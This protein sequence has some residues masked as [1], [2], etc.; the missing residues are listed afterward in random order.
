MV[1]YIFTSTET[2]R[3]VRT[4]SPGWPPRLSHSSWTM[5]APSYAVLSIILYL[6]VTRCLHVAHSPPLLYHLPPSP[7]PHRLPPPLTVLLGRVLYIIIVI[8]T[9][10]ILSYLSTNQ[11]TGLILSYLSTNQ[12]T[13]LYLLREGTGNGLFVILTE[14]V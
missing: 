2:R 3:L 10:S 14:L 13:G 8:I 11:N 7:H 12:N 1:Q 4:D 9:S 6:K 5:Q